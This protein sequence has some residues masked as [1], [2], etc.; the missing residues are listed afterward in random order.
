M[1]IERVLHPGNERIHILLRRLGVARRRHQMSAQFAQGL[2]PDL[3]VI[4][5]GLEVQAVQR[6]AADLRARVVAGEAVGV[7]QGV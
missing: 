6:E 2:L 7:D 1:G 5:R 4:R 3:R